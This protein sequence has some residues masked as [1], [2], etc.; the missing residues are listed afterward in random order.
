LHS[1]LA[2]DQLIDGL[3]FDFQELSKFLGGAVLGLGRFLEALG[4]LLEDLALE[5]DREFLRH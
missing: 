4:H 1:S 2:L 5:A 3:A